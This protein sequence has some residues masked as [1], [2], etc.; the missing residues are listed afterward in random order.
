MHVFKHPKYYEEMR[1]RAKKFQREQKEREAMSNKQGS[2][3]E[4]QATSKRQASKYKRLRSMKPGPF[5]TVIGNKQQAPGSRVPDT[6][7]P[8]T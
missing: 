5:K 6:M 8:I 3:D 2:N 1:Q 7:V 4:Q